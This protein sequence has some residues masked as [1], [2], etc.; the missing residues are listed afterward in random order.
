MLGANNVNL[1]M[2]IVRFVQVQVTQTV[3]FAIQGFFCNHRQQ[4]AQ[5]LVRLAMVRTLQQKLV[6]C[7]ILL[8]WLVRA[9]LTM[10]VLLVIQDIFYNQIQP[11]A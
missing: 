11:L 5:T 3:L 1:V 4:L 6:C 9:Q 10:S 8:A 2:L 7:A